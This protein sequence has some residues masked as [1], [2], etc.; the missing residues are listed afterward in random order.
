M[1]K[2]IFTSLAKSF[3][4]DFGNVTPSQEQ[5]SKM[6]YMLTNVTTLCSLKF[7]KKLSERET[8]CLILAA[9]GQTTSEIAALLKIRTPTVN[10]HRREILKK[11]NCKTMTQAVFQTMRYNI[12]SSFDTSHGTDI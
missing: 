12:F 9:H 3:L 10:T 8:H 11:L 4:R 1:K 5:I 6:A 2:R 7:H